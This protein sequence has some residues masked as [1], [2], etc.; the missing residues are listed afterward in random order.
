MLTLLE[1]LFAKKKKKVARADRAP[2]APKDG[3]GTRLASDWPRVRA[4]L[5]EIGARHVLVH[6]DAA[7]F[8]AAKAEL[9]GVALLWVSHVLGDVAA[10]AKHAED[11]AWGD[12]DAAVCVGT[13]LPARYRQALRLMVARDAARP[14]FW[15]GAGFEYCGGTL[16]APMEADEV[17]GLLFNHFQ[18]FFGVKDALQFR[19]EIYHGPEV[20]RFYRIL[21]PNQSLVIRLSD[22]FKARKYPVSLAAFVE[23]P[24]LT[25]DRH[26][27]L[28]LCAD[29]FWKD[30]FTTLHSAHEFNRSPDRKV[31]FRAPA[32]MV[33]EG[34]MALTIPNFDRKAENVHGIEAIAGTK[35]ST[36]PRSTGVYIE[37]STLARNGV[38]DDGMFGWRYRGFGGSNWFVLENSAALSAGHQGN[39]AGNHHASC[40][41]I[42]R[43]DLAADAEDLARYR[44][45][46]EA[47]FILDPHAV[48]ITPAGSELTFAYESDAANPDQ[49]HLRL[50]FFDAEGGH[51]GTHRFTKT[52]KGPL[53][54]DDML[55]LWGDPAGAKAC[56]AMVS[57]DWL[58]AGLRYKGFKPMSN[59][60]V[61]N[62][63]TLD[64]DFTEFQSSWRN[65]GGAVPGFP[66]WLTDQLAIVG[67][68]NV[69]GRARCDNGLRTGIV[70]LHGSGRLNYRGTARVDLI[71]INNEG[72]R[73]QVRVN[74]PAFT[75]R[76]AWLDEL[77]PNLATHLGASG[78][79]ALLVQ[80]GDADLN[81]DIVTTSPKGAVALQHLWGY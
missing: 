25:R 30:S 21:E 29:V 45:V 4:S 18:E 66:H 15:V 8:A 39:I 26:Y 80:S 79:G 53:F 28:R 23:H 50:D 37:Q 33:R 75:W 68:T 35:S 59:L 42:D 19:I 17:E 2:G 63:H 11:Q 64:Q 44:K 13:E 49:P 14:V 38:A 16:S 69:F 61:R 32:W 12:F 67:R 34:A 20:K 22:H 41:I 36:A 72:A 40:P 7:S 62:R 73:M 55:R 58:K 6:G 3:Q 10:G 81:A 1:N 78:N 65:L 57:H 31:E 70:L 77:M 52:Q 76:M 71:V 5:A 9:P 24:V 56:L 46:E 48:P 51:L 27:R 60:L 54:T 47:G 43:D 74:V